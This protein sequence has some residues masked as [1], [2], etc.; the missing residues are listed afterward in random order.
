M[1]NICQNSLSARALVMKKI[2]NL[3][4]RSCLLSDKGY[5]L[6][7]ETPQI[8]R[9]VVMT[10]ATCGLGFSW[11]RSCSLPLKAFCLHGRKEHLEEQAGHA[12]TCFLL[13]LLCNDRN[14]PLD[15]KSFVVQP[16]HWGLSN[17]LDGCRPCDCDLG[18]ALNNRWVK[19]HIQSCL[20][21]VPSESPYGLQE[22]HDSISEEGAQSIGTFSL[23]GVLMLSKI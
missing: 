11:E 13:S 22:Q 4:A 8:W 3:A 14:P 6:R 2:G 5:L 17:D 16:E 12:I 21:S 18:G 15:V 19:P 20:C 10:P 9:W 23:P 7:R 1:P